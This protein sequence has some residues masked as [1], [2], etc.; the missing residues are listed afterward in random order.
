MLKLVFHI[1]LKVGQPVLFYFHWS[2]AVFY[3]NLF[4]IA[5]STDLCGNHYRRVQLA[6]EHKQNAAVKAI[7]V[8]CN[9]LKMADLEDFNSK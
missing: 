5:C 3:V 4:N 1:S 6:F 2:F 7:P 9:F 8:K